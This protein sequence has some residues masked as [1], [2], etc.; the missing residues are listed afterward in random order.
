MVNA[1]RKQETTEKRYTLSQVRGWLDGDDPA[2][3]D[4]IREIHEGKAHVRKDFVR[5]LSE[6]MGK[7]SPLEAVKLARD[8]QVFP[9]EPGWEERFAGLLKASYLVIK[10]RI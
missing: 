3:L 5:E 6:A 7:L 10:N 4:E 8:H 9:G 2:P 1:T